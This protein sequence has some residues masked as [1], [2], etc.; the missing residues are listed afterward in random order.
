MKLEK[1]LERN[2]NVAMAVIIVVEKDNR[3]VIDIL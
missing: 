1:L 3:P 2:V